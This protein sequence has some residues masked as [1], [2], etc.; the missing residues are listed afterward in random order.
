MVSVSPK[1]S[2]PFLKMASSQ[3]SFPGDIAADWTGVTH[4]CCTVKHWFLHCVGAFLPGGF[5]VTCPHYVTVDFIFPSHAT[6]RSWTESVGCSLLFCIKVYLFI[7]SCLFTFTFSC[8]LDPRDPPSSLFFF[9]L[10][11]SSVWIPCLGEVYLWL[12]SSQKS[13]HTY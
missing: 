2:W 1:F 12:L 8:F 9:E 3:E 7:F 10:L 11:F 13:V 6:A 4:S 5:W